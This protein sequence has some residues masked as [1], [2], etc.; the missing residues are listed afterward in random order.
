MRFID[1]LQTIYVGGQVDS[2][3]IDCKDDKLLDCEA[4]DV[5]ATMKLE[6]SLTLSKNIKG[7]KKGST[8]AVFDLAKLISMLSYSEEDQDQTNDSSEDVWFDGD[9]LHYEGRNKKVMYHL[10]DPDLI[11]K[12]DL[13]KTIGDFLE[14]EQIEFTL[15]ATHMRE[16][17]KGLGVISADFIKIYT[18]GK[19]IKAEIGEIDKLTLKIDAYKVLDGKDADLSVYLD[20]RNLSSILRTALLLKGTVRFSIKENFPA[21]VHLENVGKDMSAAYLISPAKTND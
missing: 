10:A 15:N 13:E 1:Y 20:A 9:Y 4:L 16:L 14:D 17:V 18:E 3:R 21:V 12:A 2:C 8:V 19:H 11:D 7:L 5:E 6:S